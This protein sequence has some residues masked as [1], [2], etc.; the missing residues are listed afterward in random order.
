MREGGGGDGDEI[1]KDAEGCES[2]LAEVQE[3]QGDAAEQINFDTFRDVDGDVTSSEFL[4]SEI[5]AVVAPRSASSES[6]DD[7]DNAELDDGPSLSDTARAVS[8]M[9]ASQRSRASWTN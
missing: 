4:D 8:V 7:D 5:V 2:L 9:R 1:D 3:Q 6:D